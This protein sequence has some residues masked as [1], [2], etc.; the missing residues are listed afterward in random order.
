MFALSFLIITA[1]IGAGFA[2]GAEL[3]AF[4]GGSA[5]PP[6]MIALFVGVFLLAIMLIFLKAS[7]K[8]ENAGKLKTVLFKALY[9]LFYVAMIAGI[10]ELSGQATAILAIILCIAIVRFGFERLL[11]VNYILTI[12]VL[13]V[14]LWIGGTNVSGSAL[15]AS[16]SSFG[17]T[18]L[19]A[20]LYAGM[21]CSMME[22]LF[23]T[24]R[25]QFKQKEIILA[26]VFAVCVVSFFVMLLLTAIR[27]SNVG[28]A[29]PVL[30]LN[31]NFITRAVI[32]FAVLSSMYVALFNLAGEQKAQKNNLPILIGV[33][34]IA[35]ICS[36][37]GFTEI[38]GTFYPVVGAIMILYALWI[39]ISSF[40][41]RKQK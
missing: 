5:L 14:L 20:L 30:A 10:A 40:L 11:I 9:Y 13:V 29:M 2:T 32:F 41:K 15:P 28:T 33:S 21:N 22:Q 24:A 23:R 39:V 34:A 31:D 8:D 27:T 19:A 4:F 12:T 7:Q 17:G 18:M 3:Q 1:I 38:I 26:I 25:K 35:Y 37:F 16:F 36:L 6:I